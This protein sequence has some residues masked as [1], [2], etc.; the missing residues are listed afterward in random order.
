[1]QVRSRICTNSFLLSA[2]AL[3][4]SMQHFAVVSLAVL[5]QVFLQQFNKRKESIAC[6]E[7]RKGRE[8]SAIKILIIKTKKYSWR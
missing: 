6:R 3:G 8:E 5:V 1:M 7:S 4:P 2:R